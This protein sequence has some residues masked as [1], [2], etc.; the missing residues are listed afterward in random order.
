MNANGLL[1]C[2]SKGSA[3]MHYL[4]RTKAAVYSSN[5]SAAF[6]KLRQRFDVPSA[7]YRKK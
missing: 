3:F 5:R 7:P 1:P 4:Q 2:I 6:A